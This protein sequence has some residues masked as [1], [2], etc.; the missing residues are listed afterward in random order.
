MIEEASGSWH[1]ARPEAGDTTGTLAQPFRSLFINIWF[2]VQTWA[3]DELRDLSQGQLV[4]PDTL[5]DCLLDMKTVDEVA[6][7][8]IANQHCGKEEAMAF[9]VKLCRQHDRTESREADYT[10]VSTK[11]AGRKSGC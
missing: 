4:C 8:C 1:A 3:R 7:D 10:T 9:A 2:C 6:R 5:L 11:K